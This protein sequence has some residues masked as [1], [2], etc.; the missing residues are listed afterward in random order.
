MFKEGVFIDVMRKG[1]WIILDE[2]N[3][4]FIDVL[5]VLNRLLDDNCEL[6]VIEI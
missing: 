1:Y 5:E 3:L 4:V 2:L 6:F